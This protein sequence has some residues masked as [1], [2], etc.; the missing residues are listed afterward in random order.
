M[1]KVA[2]FTQRDI[3]GNEL[4]AAGFVGCCRY[5]L[6]APGSDLDKE[7]RTAEVQEKSAAGCRMAANFEWG[8]HPTNDIA[9][10][11]RHAGLFLGWVDAVGAPD[12]IPCYFSLDANNPAGSYHAYFTG[13]LRELGSVSRSGVYGNGACYRSLLNAGLVSLTWQSKSHSYAGNSAT[14]PWPDTNLVQLLPTTTV[15]GHQVDVDTVLTPYW[16]GWLLG[17]EDPM[18]TAAADDVWHDDIIPNTAGAD[19]ATN[20]T[21]QA[22]FALG[23]TRAR[24]ILLGQSVAALKTELDALKLAVSKIPTTTVPA[25]PADTAAIAA[26]VDKLIAARYAS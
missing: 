23:D 14:G 15:G 9:T 21:T 2:D 26:A 20:P 18:G 16:G 13:V 25:A 5:I 17:E 7:M 22:A 10:G 1:T 8:E 19:A 11:Q 6:N 24:T 4:K 3:T 12:W